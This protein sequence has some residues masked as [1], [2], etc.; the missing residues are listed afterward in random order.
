MNDLYLPPDELP[1]P[2]LASP[3]PE[4][5]K[6]PLELDPLAEEPL[7]LKALSFIIK[8]RPFENYAKLRHDYLR[9]V[10]INEI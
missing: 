1:N 5:P 6:P 4:P 3:K 7:K 2:P 9:L 10:N 8:S